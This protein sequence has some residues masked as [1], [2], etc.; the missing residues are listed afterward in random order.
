MAFHNNRFMGFATLVIV[1]LLI[2]NY[3]VLGQ[4][5]CSGDFGE[6]VQIC[7]NFISKTGSPVV[8][9]TSEQCCN[10]IRNDVN[11]PCVCQSITDKD[12]QVLS[13]EKIVSVAESCGKPVA[14]GSKCGSK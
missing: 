7:W 12:E 14:H 1:V 9:Y 10:T 11:I 6:L 13:M 8:P 4:P 3:Q 5:G 2:S